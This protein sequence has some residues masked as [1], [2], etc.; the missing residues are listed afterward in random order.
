M[1]RNTPRDNES[2]HQSN[3]QKALT[4]GSILAI[5]EMRLVASRTRVIYKIKGIH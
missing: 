2:T 5:P 4:H 3:K 1:A